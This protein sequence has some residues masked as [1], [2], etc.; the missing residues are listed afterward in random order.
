MSDTNTIHVA[1]TGGIGIGIWWY[2]W[3]IYGFWWGALYGIGWPIWVGFRLAKY[4]LTY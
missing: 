3:G 2:V 4:L 1:G